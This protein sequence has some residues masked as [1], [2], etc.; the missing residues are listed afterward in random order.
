[1]DARSIITVSGIFSDAGTREHFH[2]DYSVG[3]VWQGSHGF[4]HGK[5]SYCAAAGELR[6]FA[7]Y[8]IHRSRP[9]TWGYTQLF[10]PPEALEAFWH[11]LHRDDHPLPAFKA[12]VK[13]PGILPLSLRLHQILRQPHA[14]PLE[15]EEAKESF[16]NRLIRHTVTKIA[17][18]AIT[19]EAP[20]FRRAQEYIL[21]HL[22]RHDLTVASLAGELGY[23]PYHF[24][25]SFKRRF[26]ITPHR[27]ILSLRIERAKHL[28]VRGYPGALVA[29]ES[30]FSDQSHM[31]RSL[32]SYLGYTP[33]ELALSV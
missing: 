26:G 23:S 25:R 33:K 5:R 31:I 20:D 18:P 8:E 10:I 27:Y 13:D 16:L 30:G 3:I 19:Y 29:L 22:D 15:L 6:I 11:T 2:Q 1:M 7:P 9:G 14:D 17:P 28:L 21:A 4:V 24:A 32:R 12:L